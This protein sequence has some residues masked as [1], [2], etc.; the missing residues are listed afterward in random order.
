[1]D[2]YTGGTYDQASDTFV[3]GTWT[4]GTAATTFA[5]PGSVAPADVT[6]LRFTFTRADGAIWENPANPTQ[7]VHL[8]I[9]VRDTLRSDPTTPVPTD[10]ETNDPAPGEDAPGKATND[11]TSTVTGADIVFPGV[12]VTD[13]SDAT[14]TI[15][16]EHAE[17]GVRIVKDFDG[18]VSGGT[19]PPTAVIAM[20]IAVTNTGNRPIFD[21]VITDPMPTEPDGPDLRAADGV[22][23]YSY[24]LAGA[25]PTPSNGTPMPTDPAD[26]TAT[27]TGNLTSL[28]FEFPPGTVLEVGQTYT[29]TVQV[30]FRIGLSSDTTVENTAGVSGDRPWDQCESRLNPTTGEC[31]A[32]ADI[33]PIPSAAIAQSKRVKATNDDQLDVIV[34]PAAPDQSVTCT[35]D[36]DGFYGYPCTPVI[37]PGHDE[38]WQVSVENVGNLPM[39]RLVIYDRLPAP[40]DQGSYAPGDRG[41]KWRPISD[42]AYPPE[43]VDA[44]PGTTAHFSYST[45]QDY[46]MDD[47]ED[48]VDDPICP[49]DDP[50]TGWVPYDGTETQAIYDSITA[51]KVVVDFPQDAPFEPTQKVSLQG[52]TKTPA[53]VPA[54]GD[55]AIAWNSAAAS[56]VAIGVTGNSI[57]LLPTEGTKVGVATASG[58]LEVRKVVTGDG[59]KYAPAQF[60]L[61]VACTSAVGT[62]LET[63]LPPIPITVTPGTPVTVPNIPYGAECTITESTP[64]NGQTQLIVPT[65]TIASEDAGSPTT[66]VAVNRY[67]LAT[68]VVSKEVISDATDENGDPDEFGPFEVDVDCTFLGN[69]VYADGYGPDHPMDLTIEGGDEVEL[70]GLPVGAECEVV[71]SST[72]NATD[73]DVTVQSGNHDPVHFDGTRG[74]LELVGDLAGGPRNTAVVTNTFDVGELDVRKVV[75]GDGAERYGAGPFALHV[76]CT[77][78][79]DGSGPN[80]PRTVYDSPLVLGAAGPLEAEIAN[81]PVGAVC[82]VTEPEDGGATA[83]SIRPARVVIGDGEPVDVVVTN[84][85]DVGQIAVDK[86]VTGAGADDFGAGPFEVTLACTD[87]DG[88]RIGIPGGATRALV[89]GTQVVYDELPVGARCTVTESQDGDANSTS[90]AVTTGNGDPVVTDGSSADVVVPRNRLGEQTTASVVVTNTF[91]EGA[92]RVDK[93]VDGEGA[94]LYGSG[95]FEVSLACTF[96]GSDV[97]IPGGATRSLTPGTPVVYEG[98]PAGA[99]CTVTEP[100]TGGATTTTISAVDDGDPGA[101]LVPDAGAV[102]VTVTNSFDVGEIRVLKT[103]TGQDA[104]AH[105]GDVFTVSLACTQD[106]DGATVPVDIPG[107]PTRTLSAAGDWIAVY[108]DLPQGAQCTVSETDAGSADDVQITVDGESTLTD[109]DAGT[110]QSA[111]FALPV[112]DDV[113]APVDVVNTWSSGSGAAGTTTATS[114]SAFAASGTGSSSRAA[115]DPADCADS[116]GGVQPSPGGLPRTGTDAVTVLVWAALLMAA[117]TALVVG[118]R[119]RA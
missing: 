51:L 84:R 17:N 43:L 33:T 86:V 30:Q 15:T 74:N 83:T 24:A 96:D 92:V 77:F 91:D 3:G 42:L 58:P 64:L 41:S 12:P 110:P 78:D 11:V 115:I 61:N 39:S 114:T 65:V 119:R 29:I 105:A 112:G 13:T 40:G 32:D 56:G 60:H 98:L 82:R 107:G 116:G 73:I 67:D 28:R 31:E 87:A 4:N 20:H 71:E 111:S 6:G 37:A 47:I 104:Q 2:A 38:T 101:V 19:A 94:D 45:V 93:V 62:F 21:P 97:E 53:V 81:L 46:C 69:P 59:K 34:D 113:C 95:P 109:P 80:P 102:D 18:T 35:P 117:G 85:F 63:E 99:S 118:R 49:T 66:I 75:T 8:E 14:A 48:P 79:D 22:E 72:G 36:A 90:I 103:L 100:T 16:Y 7:A 68:L 26:V 10:L 55:R 27:S 5:L 44:P 57:N 1:M 54:D 50:T 23:P 106:V 25:A 88:D 89:P 76:T 70:T 108:E 9:Q 52:T